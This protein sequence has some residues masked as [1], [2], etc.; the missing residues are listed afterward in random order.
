MWIGLLLVICAISWLICFDEFAIIFPL[1]PLAIMFQ[2][3]KPSIHEHF[4]CF[5][6]FIIV[7]QSFTIHICLYACI[8]ISSRWEILLV[9]A[10]FS[11]YKRSTSWNSSC[12]TFMTGMLGAQ[13]WVLSISREG[14]TFSAFLLF[15]ITQNGPKLWFFDA[16]TSRLFMFASF[17]LKH[18]SWLWWYDCLVIR[19]MGRILTDFRRLF[20]LHRLSW[21]LH[22]FN[23]FNWIQWLSADF[24]NKCCVSVWEEYTINLARIRTACWRLFCLQLGIFAC[25]LALGCVT[26]LTTVDALIKNISQIRYSHSLFIFSLDILT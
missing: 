6:H 4:G 14:S 26:V 2:V 25:N 22:I 17:F 1:E 5:I 3:F 8:L 19:V 21:Q 15:L 7:F 10:H 23:C 9:N 24:I 16:F 12:F 13:P 18:W 11:T 20:V